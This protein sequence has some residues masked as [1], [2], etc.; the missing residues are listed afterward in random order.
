M[1][2]VHKI[3]RRYIPAR[4]TGRTN[5]SEGLAGVVG[6]GVDWVVDEIPDWEETVS[7]GRHPVRD[8]THYKIFILR[9]PTQEYSYLQG[10]LRLVYFLQYHCY[11]RP[12]L[13]HYRHPLE[14]RME[15]GYMSPLPSHC[16][17]WWHWKRCWQVHQWLRGTERYTLMPSEQTSAGETTMIN[18]HCSVFLYLYLLS[19]WLYYHLLSQGT[20]REWGKKWLIGEV[21]GSCTL[22]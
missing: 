8:N 9:L 20:A 12:C 4:I 16:Q 13:P 19:H 21:N 18:A 6:S 1:V 7:I 10:G 17:S 11:H 3:V 2:G 22:N 15:R 14:I 5:D